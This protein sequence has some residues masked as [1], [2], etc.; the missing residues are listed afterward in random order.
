MSRTIVAENLPVTLIGG[1][2]VDESTLIDA[3]SRTGMLV[4]ADGGAN[5]AVALGHMP[6]VVIGDFDSVDHA[7]Q[8]V[9]GQEALFPIAE[10]DT[11]DFDK[12]LRNI[13]APLIIAVGFT[14]ARVDHELAALGCLVRYAARPV[15]MVNED[16]VIMV[17]PPEIRLPLAAGV[18]VS[19]FPLGAA[20]G[21]ST[22]LQWPIDGL[23]MAPDGMIGTS[24]IS[25]GPVHL[26]MSTSKMLLILPRTMLDVAIKAMMIAP[27]WPD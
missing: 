22:G 27:R 3:I 16:D 23:E 13:D 11:T 20:S 19:L 1:G 2:V 15:V 4:A 5:R 14:G 26:T 21:T 7:T 24:N 6:K 9:L 25:T 18:R 8:D 10:Q 12:C 17:C